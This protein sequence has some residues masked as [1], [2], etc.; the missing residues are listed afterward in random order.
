MVL[1]TSGSWKHLLRNTVTFL[2]LFACLCALLFLVTTSDGK[3]S[4]LA[5]TVAQSSTS[6]RADGTEQPASADVPAPTAHPTPAP[7]IAPIILQNPLVTDASIPTRSE[8]RHFIHHR[9]PTPTPS[10]TPPP[11]TSLPDPANPLQSLP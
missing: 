9:T 1:W 5:V 4:G 6:T 11:D 3:W 2:L 8:H 7:Y 10:A